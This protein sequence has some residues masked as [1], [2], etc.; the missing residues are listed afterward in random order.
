MNQ[1]VMIALPKGRLFDQ[2][3]SL[4]AEAGLRP[5]E[6]DDGSRK[7]VTSD[8]LG[9]F[10][11]VSLKPADIPVYV[12]SGAIDG[13]IVG[14]DVL[15]ELE[16]DVYEPVDLRIGRCTLVVAAP[17]GLSFRP[18]EMLRIATKYPR[19]AERHFRAKHA[20]VHIVKL[21]GSVEI[22]P[23]LGLADAIVDLV[24][25]GRTL[26]E[27]GMTVIE[28]VSRISAK[29]IVNRTAMKM[30]AEE[31]NHVIRELDRVVYE[32]H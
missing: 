28:E 25:T 15:R 21:D 23:L 8:A 12:E 14:T 6:G 24:E 18:G 32:N 20:H 10:E 27:N 29:F 3:R 4:L 2:A 17:D 26:R 13:G 11:F 7:L 19:T 31:I 16:S 22:A 9:R 30:K 1:K 5:K